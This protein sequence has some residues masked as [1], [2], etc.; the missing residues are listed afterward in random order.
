MLPPFDPDA[1][2]AVVVGIDKEVLIIIGC[3][4]DVRLVWLR[5]IRNCLIGEK[6]FGVVLA[7]D[8]RV[9]GLSDEAAC[10]SDQRR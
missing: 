4:E 9:V 10:K 6:P 8:Q 7:I 3:V 2:G 1:D 5:D